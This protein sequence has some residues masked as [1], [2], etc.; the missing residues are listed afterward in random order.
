M[1]ENALNKNKLI[2]NVIRKINNN[3]KLI[4]ILLSSCFTIFLFIQLFGFYT[5]S[6][7]KKNSIDFFSSQNFED[8]TLLEKSIIKLS[9]ENDF[10]GF[11]SKLELIEIYIKDENYDFAINL[12]NELLKDNNLDSIYQSA[13]ASKAAYQFIDINL[14]DFSKNYSETIKSFI[15]FIDDE[16]NNFQGAKLELN[17]LLKILDL[18]K[19]NN[20]YT[21]FHE[22]IDLYNNI[23]SSDSASSIIKERVKK[24]HEF[25]SYK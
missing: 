7:I 24:I 10:Y 4:I 18:E 22:A 12:Y 13:I 11:L 9:E 6:K 19:N 14:T 16:L 17:Y 15:N 25:Y 20:E 3:L 5:S 23:M 8:Q 2:S 1:N 21:N